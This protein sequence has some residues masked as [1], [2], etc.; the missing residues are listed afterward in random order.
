M[1]NYTPISRE[2]H[3][4]RG[5][6]CYESRSGQGGKCVFCPWHQPKKFDPDPVD[7]RITQALKSGE[8]VTIHS[9]RMSLVP[10]VVL[11]ERVTIIYQPYQA[12]QN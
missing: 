4:E 7:E 10:K 1:A 12:G 3:L 11:Q 2:A 9:N 5:Y 6:C 8:T